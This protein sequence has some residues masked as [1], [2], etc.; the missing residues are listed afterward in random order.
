MG[1]GGEGTSLSLMKANK[2]EGDWLWLAAMKAS[3]PD[4]LVSSNRTSFFLL[5]HW[6]MALF[7]VIHLLGLGSNPDFPSN[8]LSS[9]E[10]IT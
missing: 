7:S 4:C 2:D 9:L 6:G 5:A 8:K 10:E 3:A 1:A